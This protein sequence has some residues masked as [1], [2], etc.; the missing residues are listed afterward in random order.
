MASSRETLTKGAAVAGARPAMLDL[1]AYP[2][3]QRLR[4]L[5]AKAD[6]VRLIWEDGAEV[7]LPAIWFR[8]NCPCPS[9]RHEETLERR[10]LFLDDRQPRLEKAA[11]IGEGHLQLLYADGHASEFDAGW[12]RH[13]ALDLPGSLEVDPPLWGAGHE[14]ARLSHAQVMGSEAG[15]SEWLGVILRDGLAILEGMPAEPGEMVKVVRRVQEPKPTNFGPTF[16][17]MTHPKPVS[18]AYTAMALEPHADL[19]NYAVPPDFQVLACLKNDAKGGGSI[20]VNAHAV[21]KALNETSPGAFEILSQ[22]PVE[23]RF[24]DDTCDIRH[25][26]PVIELDRGGQVR[27][28]RFNNWLRGTLVAPGWRAAAWYAAY[29]ELWLL[30]RDPRFRVTPRLKAGEMVVFDNVR[31]LHGREAYDPASGG[32]HLQGCYMDRD[33]ILSR[34]RLSERTTGRSTV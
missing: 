25:Q 7:T 13:H 28:L 18:S 12:L 33:W 30:V 34:L 10:Y 32:R 27:R 29:A 26:A 3:D 4:A 16:E 17:V 19:I 1:A 9:C 6:E 5:E 24:H 8:D 2:P 14:I 15:L 11:L 31:V 20:F 21:A 22:T 23:F